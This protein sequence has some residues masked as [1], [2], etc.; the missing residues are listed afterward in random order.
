M[1]RLLIMVLTAL[2][3]WAAAQRQIISDENALPREVASFHAV[4]VSDAITLYLSQ[5]EQ[6][7]LVVSAAREEY[8]DQIRTNVENGTLNIW[9]DNHGRSMRNSGTMK[10][11]VY[12]SF[13]DL[14]RIEASG[15]SDVVVSGTVAVSNLALR[16]SGA[17]D[18]KGNVEVGSMNVEISGASDALISGKAGVLKV[19]ANGASDLKGYDLVSEQ[20]SVVASGASDVKVTVNKELSAKASGA[21]GVYYKG[22]AAIGEVKTSGASTISKRS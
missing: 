4:K 20:C 19:D 11:R 21:S 14:D 1:K 8:R 7:V 18:F 3:L 15:A 9:Y 16:M 13:K 12:L 2:P 22:A 6:E 5:G 10:L 17:S